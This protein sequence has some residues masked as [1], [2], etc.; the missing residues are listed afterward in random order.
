MTTILSTMRRIAMAALIATPI[1]TASCGSKK[2]VIDDNNKGVDITTGATNTGN[3]GTAP[4]VKKADNITYL[5]KV[6]ANQPTEKAMVANI[7]FNLKSG[8]KD[9]TVGGK[10][11]MKKDQV[12]RIQLTPMGLMEVGRLEFTKDS[13]L[14][15][16]RVHKQF[17]KSSYDQVSF[18]KNNGIDFYALQALFW[19]QLF[20]PGERTINKNLLAKYEVDG[21]NITLQQGKMNYRWQ[22]D[23]SVE[24]ILSALATYSSTQHGKSQLGWDYSDFKTFG[25]KPFP[26]QHAIT[27]STTKKTLNVNITLKSMKA[28]DDWDTS[29]KVSGKYKPVQL[30]EVINKILNIQ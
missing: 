1:L 16:D 26:A 4:A 14:I 29:T 11:S 24:R 28:D 8:K 7:D 17:L 25:G 2:T 13:V 10:L 21:S 15:I 3:T 20:I 12:V 19:N 6:T 30:D 9:I 18:L 22:T 5:A 27:I 23:N